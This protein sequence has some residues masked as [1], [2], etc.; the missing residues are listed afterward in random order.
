MPLDLKM[1]L[2]EGDGVK[3]H[4]I[5]LQTMK[6]KGRADM[7][8]LAAAS[9]RS[10]TELQP[11]MQELVAAGSCQEGAGRYRLTPAGRDELNRVLQL[12]KQSVDQATLAELYETFVPINAEYKHL[13]H[14][15]QLRDGSPNDHQDTEYDR[16]VVDAF[17]ALHKNFEPLLE[18]FVA[19]VARLATYPTRFT[20]ALD[21]VSA[22]DSSW[23]TKPLLNSHHTVWF[24]LHE[25]L[26]GLAGHTRQAEAEAGRAD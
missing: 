20:A 19:K 18:A 24:E 3:E 12:E 4:L 7:D 26:I 13:V 6:F 16:G 5:L 14:K 21:K 2:T 9:G 10:Q 11:L 22:G 17:F 1:M 15:W 25:E 23:L 8:M